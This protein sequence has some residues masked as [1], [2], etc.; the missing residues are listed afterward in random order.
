MTIMVKLEIAQS[1]PSAVDVHAHMNSPEFS[2]DLTEVLERAREKRVLVITSATRLSEIPKTLE[3][4]A[5]CDGICASL[6]FQPPLEFLE[7]ALLDAEGVCDALRK[8]FGKGNVVGIGEVGLD[9]VFKRGL[10][11]TEAA[12][13][14]EALQN[15]L[16]SK[17]VRLASKLDAPLITHSRSAGRYVLEFLE[18]WTESRRPERV[19]MHAFD[20]KAS[21]AVRAAQKLGFLFSIPPSVVFSVQKQKLVEKLPLESLLLETDSPVLGPARGERNEPVNVFESARV[22]AKIKGIPVE[23]VL[24]KTTRTALEFFRI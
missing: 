15:D 12:R 22:I 1:A 8:N 23:S 19:L 9:F 7:N 13:R 2:Q 18:N 5:K 4:A 10:S 14:L 24:D 16:F 3:L 21:L 20:G 11:G 17:F 6:G